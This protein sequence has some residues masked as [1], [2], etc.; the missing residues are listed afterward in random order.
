VT[1]VDLIAPPAAPTPSAPPAPPARSSPPTSGP[2]RRVLAWLSAEEHRDGAPPRPAGLAELARRHPLLTDALLVVA[3]ALVGTPHV[4]VRGGPHVNPG[5]YVAVVALLLPLVWRR[6][7]PVAV[8]G[9]LCVV[10]LIQVITRQATPADVSILISLYT[11]ATRCP[12]RISLGAFVVA[13]FGVIVATH[14]NAL[15]ASAARS[16]VF[17]SAMVAAA[18][19]L[20]KNLRTRREY[21]TAMV[22]RTE[23]LER[24]RD[25][26]ARIAVAAERASI[27]REMH[28]IVAHS[29][30]VIITMADAA[31]AKF[32]SD[33]D[34]AQAAIREVGETGRQALGETRRLL[35]V[36]RT[37][38]TDQGFVPQPG[39]DDIDALVEHVRATG[40]RTELTVSGRPFR[41]PEG[42]QLA[43]YRITQEALTNC[44]KHAAGATKVAVTLRYAE[45][46]I[47]LGVVDDGDANVTV[48]SAATTTGH[49]I[50]GMHERAALYNGT[51]IAAPRSGS[52]WTVTACLNV[53]D[54]LSAST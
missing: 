52:G 21:V 30:A 41:V 5:T 1:A 27:A 37:D 10:G 46:A 35:G 38:G 32:R 54:A 51:V 29:L 36:L 16:F 24:E 33:P 48:A 22:D 15:A 31:G 40:L 17:L 7:Y 18:F 49:G 11:V 44:M 34:R 23:R 9:F 8:F 26:Q 2:V 42:A 4:F 50:V 45:P 39:L 47:E 25:Q 13:E 19:F 3:L 20:G 53:A 28:D 6:R 43:V 14:D 12:P